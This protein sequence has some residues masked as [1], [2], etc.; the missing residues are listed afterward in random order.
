MKVDAKSKVITDYD[1]T[2]ANTHDSK[3]FTQFYNEEESDTVYADSAYIGHE[4]PKNIKREICERAYRNKPLS[5]EQKAENK[6]K[7]K[8]R[9]RIEHVFGFIEGHMHGSTFRGKG[10]ERARFNI[11]LTNL[12]YN[13]ERFAF[14]SRTELCKG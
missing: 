13:L 8:V 14:F 4:M 3:V 10:I 7:S 1:I 12:I 11:G 5:D 9:A 2:A 6:R